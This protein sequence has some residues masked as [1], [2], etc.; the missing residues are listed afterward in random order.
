M[1]KGDEI[2]DFA[3]GFSGTRTKQFDQF[4]RLNQIARTEELVALTGHPAPTVRGYA[5][6]ALVER[7]YERLDDIYEA[8]AD[9]KAKVLF[10]QGC[11]VNELTVVVFMCWMKYDQQ[12]FS[13]CD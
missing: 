13:R 5:F 2:D 7:K 12:D 11:L 3:I 8:H 10:R 9:D 4:Y 1:E 6:W